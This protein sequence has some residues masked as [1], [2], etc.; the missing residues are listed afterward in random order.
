MKDLLIV[1]AVW[2]IVVFFMYGADKLKAIKGS[3]R[4]SEQTLI[5][6]AFLFGG[7]GALFGMFVFRHK[8]KHLKFRILLPIALIFNIF[9]LFEAYKYI[10]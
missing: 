6:S 8:T 5:T 3:W 1:I 4:I 9:L 7:I 10:F 2:N